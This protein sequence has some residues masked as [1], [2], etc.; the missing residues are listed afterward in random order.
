MRS[1][2]LTTV[3]AA[4]S[5]L[6]ALAPAAAS[7]HHGHHFKPSRGSA[8]ACRVTLQVAP[9]LVYA[10]GKVTASGRLSCTSSGPVEGQTVTLYQGSVVTPGYSVAGTATT[11]KTGA[12]KIETATPLTANS[13]FYAVADSAQSPYRSVKVAAQVE[14]KGPAENVQLQAGLRTGRRNRVTFTGTVSPADIGAQVILQRQD[15]LTGNEWHRIGSG[16]VVTGPSPTVGSFSITHRFLV[17]GD[18]NIRVLLRSQRRN[19]STPSNFLT[20]EISQAQNA[21]LTI[22][23][24]ADPITFGQPVTISGVAAGAA[25]TPVTLLAHTAHQGGFGP[26]AEA[27]T[28]ATGGYEFPVQSPVDNTF[29]EVKGNGRTSAVLYEA[30]RN[31][32]TASVSPGLSVEVG[33]TL[34]FSGNVSPERVGHVIYLERENALGTA[35]RVEQVSTIQPGSVF[36]IEHTVYEAG[37]SVLRV[38]IPGDPQNGGG[39]SETFTIQVTPASSANSLPPEAPGNTT[40]PPEGQV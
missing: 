13:R 40:L 20:Y 21:S 25:N 32:I 36:S 14:L 12:Y 2:K 8:A 30:V 5:A 23:S 28:N 9:R 10:G 37:T 22:K 18:A 1:I 6:L 15:A 34:K 17:P 16:L 11:E 39:I 19:A 31:V 4:A 38:R 29:Y 24:S 26:V 33:Q 7:A 27:T 35:F 3:F